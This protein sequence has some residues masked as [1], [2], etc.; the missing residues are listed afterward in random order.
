M[1]LH[2]SVNKLELAG[3]T[4]IDV[5]KQP[6]DLGKLDNICS[7]SEC[8]DIIVDDLL[9]FIPYEALPGVVQHISSKLRHKGRITLIFTDFNSIIRE[10][11]IG[12]IDEKTLNKIL[13][14]NGAKGCFSSDYLIGILK[15]IQINI[16]SISVGEQT[17]IIAE[18]P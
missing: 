18:R 16:V 8:T 12:N 10:F 14:L 17:I 11:N 15:E 3:Y 6:I 1:K 4:N 9:R 13:F 2:L 5:T 7:T